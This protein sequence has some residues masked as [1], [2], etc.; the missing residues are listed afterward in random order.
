MICFQLVVEFHG[1]FL[2]LRAEEPKERAF[3]GVSPKTRV[4]LESR[5]DAGLDRTWP[6][7]GRRAVTYCFIVNVS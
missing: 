3:G 1:R 4:L 2:L 6:C 5:K 7:L